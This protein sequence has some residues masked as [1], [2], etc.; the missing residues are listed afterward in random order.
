LV[1][2]MSLA[3]TE[4]KKELKY[5]WL[6]A[7]SKVVNYWKLGKWL[8]KSWH[9][10]LWPKKIATSSNQAAAYISSDGPHGHGG[11]RE[12]A[13]VYS[14]VTYIHIAMIVCN[15]PISMHYHYIIAKMQPEEHFLIAVYSTCCT[16]TVYHRVPNKTD[17][18]DHFSSEV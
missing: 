5:K 18:Y 13:W 10:L 11:V 6:A 4:A 3:T 2:R 14:K 16:S 1:G 12:L 9:P 8:C 15:I 17:P 7:T